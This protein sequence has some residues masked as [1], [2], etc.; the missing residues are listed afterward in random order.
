MAYFNSKQLAAIAICASLWA[1]LNW[2]VTPIFWDLTH[3]PI[4]CDMV[5]VSLLILTV[6]WIRKLGAASMMG[7]IA[8][9]LNFILRPSAIH[10]LGFTVASIVF[11]VSTRLIT[12]EKGFNRRVISNFAIL[13]TSFLS[14]L[15]A[16][17]IIGSLFMN[18][19]SLS[20]MY[21]GILFFAMLHGAG[22]ILG[23]VIGI[24]IVRG[25]EVRKII[26]YLL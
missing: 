15:V 8:T 26:P 23:G 14:A 17:F 1:I 21:G 9:M 18:P 12:Y 24:V 10:F 22:G 20:S 11:D 3:L 13:G 16:G 6:W 25:L 19:V 7:A 2:T 5:G 4:L